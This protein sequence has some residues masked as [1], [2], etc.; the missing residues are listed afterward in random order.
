MV[1]PEFDLSP[2]EMYA[3]QTGQSVEERRYP[4][5]YM[6]LIATRKPG[7]YLWNVFLP[8]LLLSLMALSVFV[9]SSGDTSDRLG[10]IL[11]LVLT[12][13]A[14]KFVVAQSLPKIPY[15]TVLDWC[16]CRCQPSLRPILLI[17]ALR[18]DEPVYQ[19]RTRLVHAPLARGGGERDRIF[20]PRVTGSIVRASLD[21]LA[22]ASVRR[23]APWGGCLCAHNSALHHLRCRPRV[24]SRQAAESVGIGARAQAYGL[25]HV[26]KLKASPSSLPREA[27]PSCSYPRVVSR[28]LGLTMLY[29]PCLNSALYTILWRLRQSYVIF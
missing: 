24:W 14:F 23:L 11:T 1:M 20:A 2:V 12:S 21:I 5:L 29:T 17:Y 13:V 25:A 15:N 16:V 19:V 9:V 4:L 18:S 28:R 27:A 3:T 7:Y 6:A 8:T 22:D 26:S 10:V